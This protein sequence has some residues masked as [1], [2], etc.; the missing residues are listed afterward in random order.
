MMKININGVQLAYD[1]WGKVAPAIVFLHGFGLDRSIW[2]ELVQKHL[3]NQQVLLLDV[4]GHGES[5]VPEGPYLMSLLAEDV[6]KFLEALGIK[7]AIVCG[8]SMG[9]Y[10][11]LAF[12]AHYPEMLAGLGLITTNAQADS[13]EKRNGR[14]ALIEEVHER[15][16]IA[17]AETLAPRLS[18]DR[19][20]INLSHRLI[21][22]TDPEGLIGA[23]GGMAERPDRRALLPKIIVPTLVVAGEDDQ[24]TSLRDA[25]MMA[26]AL[27]EGRMLSLPGV[28]HMPM[29]EATAELGQS[30]LSLI[31]Q[32]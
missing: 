27:P 11:A 5:D 28:G 9:G 26:E 2:H 24:I 16:A 18:H 25:K 32:R 29:A 21:L 22:N 30:L 23:L 14:Y 15:G 19:N 20:V 17:V 4:R 8:H 10:I 12:A 3:D 6:A 7:R 1:F 13:D 31:A